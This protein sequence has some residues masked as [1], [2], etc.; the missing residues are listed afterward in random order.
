MLRKT[1]L[2]FLLALFFVSQIIAGTTGKITG[3]VFDKN[4][5]EPLPGV[6]I[7]IEGLPLGASTDIDGYFFILNVPPGTYRV[8]AQMVGYTTQI[9]ENVRVTADL[10]TQISF[11]LSEQIIEGET[12][13]V[14]A[15]RPII[16][17]DETAKTAV[18]GAKSFTELPIKH[19]DEALTIQAGFTTD[20][21]G[22][23]HVRGGRTGEVA[24][25]IDGIYVRDPYSGNFG[26]QIDKYSIEELQI[27]TGGFNAEYGQAMSGI[28]NIVTKEGG[29]E[30]H[31]RLEYE[32]LRINSSPYRQ[33]DWMLNTDITE[34]LSEPDVYLYR[35]ALRDS[36]D[37]SLYTEP[38]YDTKG[39]P[40]YMLA[41]G[42]LSAN[43]SGPVPFVRNITF[44][45]SGRI[46]NDQGYLPW[47]Y[48]K[49]RE[50]NVKL[51][52]FASS[53]KLN[54]FMQINKRY[55]K[56]YSH[57]WKYNPQGYEDRESNV[58]RYGLILTHTISN[59]TF[60]ELRL[61]RF[62]REYNQYI[63][64]KFATFAFNDSLNTYELIESNFQRSRST[65]DGF[66]FEGDRGSID[67]RD[68]ITYTL[69]ADLVSQLNRSNQIKVGIQYLYH[70]ISRETYIQPWE[71]ENHRY[72]NFNRNPIELALYVQDKLEY[73]NF[74]I[75]IGL[76]Y[77]YSDPKHTMWPDLDIPGYI[78]ENG[79]WIAS[80]EVPVKPKTQLS[81][82]IGI[83]FPVTERTMFY[84][85]Y[86]HFYQIPSYLE[87][88]GPH[89][90]DEDQPLIGN[91]AIRPQSTVSFE[92]GVR[93]QLGKDY[94]VNLNFFFKDI[95]NLAGSTYHGFFPYEYTLYDNS[96][97]G[98]VNGIEL[99]INKRFSY[100]F[101]GSLNYT[102]S[103]A[104]GNESDPREG[105]ADYK[106]SN[107][108]LRPK[109]LFYLDFDRRHDLS[110]SVH[111]SSP[112]KMGFNIGSFYPFGDVQLNILF[113]AFSGLPYTPRVD[114][115]GTGIR[116]EKNSARLPPTYN[117]DLK[118]QKRFKVLGFYSTIFL[119]MNNVF[120]RRNPVIVWS[121]TGQPWD[122]GQ[123][124]SSS[125][126][127][128]Y[129]PTHV[130]EPLRISLGI[131]MD[132]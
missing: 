101:G 131:R 27:V 53:L 81:P 30:Y 128:I 37:K 58:D 65:S 121:E 55:Y 28:I 95:T 118:I 2:L 98:S 91:P 6:N 93:Q 29:R 110:A 8:S 40:Q 10:T 126:D 116:V 105:Y 130:S 9:I 100:Y 24:Y 43:I 26:S 119:V 82:R 123:Y 22:E 129:N 85:S 15:E 94:S 56:P 49:R 87:M 71:G 67:F 1:L 89:K 14:K 7:L 73:E 50:F 13:V 108:H 84:T 60:Y 12:I 11:R 33:E 78:D 44:F 75:N 46:T 79:N 42:N 120:N 92:A 125:K 41:Q 16:Q 69:K 66:Y 59:S 68:I 4:S 61:S 19:F 97:Y 39:L 45:A 64:G 104:K 90:V 36:V 25:M 83:G 127:R 74:I 109:T 38:V 23:I 113:V 132:F 88:Y 96:D 20:E 63:P 115:A 47:G 106:R 52:Y 31:G 51:T 80:E 62:K 57:R 17:R 102:Y 18:I 34:G 21:N 77:D 117:L 111:F 54:L 107:A 124:T 112:K 72:E 114:D 86:G 48:D 122:R 3:Q 103:V 70:D 32:S 99:T 5:N 35:D 76:R